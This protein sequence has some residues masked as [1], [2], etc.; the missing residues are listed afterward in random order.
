MASKTARQCCTAV[1][2]SSHALL[3][4]NLD[5]F[6]CACDGI[7]AQPSRQ[8]RITGEIEKGTLPA[9][10]HDYVHDLIHKLPVLLSLLHVSTNYSTIWTNQIV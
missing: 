8:K 7:L 6:G 3:W 10:P 5:F 1:A 4:A 9:R 2:V